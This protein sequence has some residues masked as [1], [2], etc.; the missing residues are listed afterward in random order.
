M[1]A[2][3]VHRVAAGAMAERA[4]AVVTDRI[5][6]GAAPADVAVLARVNATLLPV[7]VALGE[8]GVPR[9][10]PLDASVLGRTGIRAAL[11]YLRLGLDPDR[12]RREDIRETV[13]RPSR[14]LST[15]VKPLLQ[16]RPT[17]TLQSLTDA[18]GLLDGRAGDRLEEYCEDLGTLTDAITAGADTRA[19]L[20]LIRDVIGLGEAMDVLDSSTTR[21]EGSSHGDDLDALLQLADMHP[22][23]VTFREWLV[24]SLQDDGD[25]EGVQLS[26]VHR[27]K[28]MEWDHVVVF[29]ANS[30]LFPHRLSDD[31][32][33]ERRVFH[34]ALT[35]CRRSVAVVANA[36]AVSAFVDELTTPA[37]ATTAD[38]RDDGTPPAWP[39]RIEPT[40]QPDG[41]VV[42][43]PGL[44]VVLTGGI[45]ARVV[46]A[47]GAGGVRLVDEAG[48]RY[49]VAWDTEVGVAV[50]GAADRVEGRRLA[51]VAA[52]APA[53]VGAAVG[54]WSGARGAGGGGGGLFG[55]GGDG[56]PPEAQ[57]LFEALREWRNTV[58]SSEG[59][60]A[61]VVFSNDTLREIAVRRPTSPRELSKVKGVGPTKL[62]RYADDVL[63]IVDAHTSP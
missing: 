49:E 24:A 39:E 21:P 62:E 10:C 5:E 37:H 56:L 59:L 27:V 7:Q 18:A 3:T 6:A 19:C 46:T 28:G 55:D 53:G 60:P 13:N 43:Q 34:V 16:R 30:G 63:A 22:D 11:A 57:P 33:E 29:G 12:L 40:L 36:A 14:K 2:L 61:Y 51:Q 54:A 45:V 41:S 31:V 58:A 17:F 23:P 9:T 32:E 38:R 26:T 44:E 15:A 47:T 1:S 52:R 50:D 25:P 48:V 4:V 35:R 42:A 20:E 8:A